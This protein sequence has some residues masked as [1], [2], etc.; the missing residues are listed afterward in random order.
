MNFVI[1]LTR[2]FVWAVM[3]A[4]CTFG[5]LLGCILTLGL[6]YHSWE[7]FWAFVGRF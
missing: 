2:G 5:V 1:S 3:I 7:G 6:G 4:C